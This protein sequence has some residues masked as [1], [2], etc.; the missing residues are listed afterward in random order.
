MLVE[1]KTAR[2][3]SHGK[4]TVASIITHYFI[5]IKMEMR[6]INSA[7]DALKIAI[8]ATMTHQLIKM[9]KELKQNVTTRHAMEDITKITPTAVIL[10]S[11]AAKLSI[12]T[13]T[14]VLTVHQAAPHVTM[15]RETLETGSNEI[16]SPRLCTLPLKQS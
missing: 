8:T 5:L 11:N 1:K 13:E 2:T 4:V 9:T 6:R 3:W 16:L 7:R 12:S 15:D 10:F 14:H